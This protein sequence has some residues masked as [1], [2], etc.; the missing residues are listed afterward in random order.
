M[1]S[2]GTGVRVSFLSSSESKRICICFPFIF[3]A[4]IISLMGTNTEKGPWCGSKEENK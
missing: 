3:I 4:L 2:M 1:T